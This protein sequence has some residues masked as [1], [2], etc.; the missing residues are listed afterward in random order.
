MDV[1]VFQ[2]VHRYVL[3]LSEVM[4]IQYIHVNS[5]IAIGPAILQRPPLRRR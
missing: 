2:G 4:I 5:R 1:D 3:F